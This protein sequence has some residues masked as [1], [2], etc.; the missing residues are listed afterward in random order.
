MPHREL[1]LPR[2]PQAAVGQQM[3]RPLSVEVHRGSPFESSRAL[4]GHRHP[5]LTETFPTTAQ[6]RDIYRADKSLTNRQGFLTARPAE[7]LRYSA[8]I[9]PSPDCKNFDVNKY[10]YI[11]VTKRLSFRTILQHPTYNWWLR[12][13]TRLVSQRALRI[14]HLT[15]ITFLYGH[16][17]NNLH[18]RGLQSRGTTAKLLARPTCRLIFCTSVLFLL[19]IIQIVFIILFTFYT[20]PT[21][22]TYNRYTVFVV[23]AFH[24]KS[25][26]LAIRVLFGLLYVVSLFLCKSSLSL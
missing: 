26:F 8:N 22:Y 19:Y 6:R 23:F 1:G 9:R 21:S 3:R 24:K 25:S 5:W 11:C 15:L 12:R 16:S 20:V 13:W 18:S 2:H 14:T 10:C 7:D 4:G 17:W